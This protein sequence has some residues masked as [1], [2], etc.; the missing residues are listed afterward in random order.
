MQLRVYVVYRCRRT[1]FLS[2]KRIIELLHIGILHIYQ[3]ALTKCLPDEMII[4]VN[5]INLG[6]WLQV[7][8]LTDVLVIY[9]IDRNALCPARIQ[10]I[11]KVS[12][13]L[14][15]LLPKADEIGRIYNLS[16][17]IL[18][19]I[20]IRIPSVRSLARSASERISTG[21]L[22]ALC[23]FCSSYSLI[24]GTASYGLVL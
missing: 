21:V 15:F 3:P 6:R 23:H 14:L 16:V 12:S 9:L 8:L 1:S 18:I 7:I 17:V 4:G 24:E 20:G 11:L 13:D 10:S 19:R 22:S 2:N 5:V